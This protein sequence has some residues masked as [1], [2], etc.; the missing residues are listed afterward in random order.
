MLIEQVI[1]REAP[2]EP[3]HLDVP[4]VKLQTIKSALDRALGNILR[5][6]VRYAKDIEIIGEVDG[7]TLVLRI[8]DRGPGVAEAFLPRLFEPF[9][10]P[11]VA[12]SR[13]TGGSGLGLAIAKRCIE[14]CQ[15]TLSAQQR[16]GGGLILKC[17]VPLTVAA[18]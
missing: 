8:Q 4:E 10:R 6:A 9:F 18:Q 2:D 16:D 11:E 3:I 17:R 13:H 5:N 7:H 12:R 1:A 14:A 15:G